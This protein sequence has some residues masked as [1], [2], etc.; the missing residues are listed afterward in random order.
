MQFSW[1]QLVHCLLFVLKRGKNWG[2]GVGLFAPPGL[3]PDP[4]FELEFHDAGD[5][6]YDYQDNYHI[7]PL[8]PISIK[9]D[10]DDEYD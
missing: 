3:T 6:E 9:G 7:N 4:R 2:E 5:D 1:N 8:A 10:K